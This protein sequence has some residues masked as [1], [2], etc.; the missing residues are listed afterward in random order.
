MSFN[1]HL[2][3]EWRP[4]N[5]NWR[6]FNSW[7]CKLMARVCFLFVANQTIRSSCRCRPQVIFWLQIYWFAETVFCISV[8]Q[9][10]WEC[11]QTRVTDTFS[12][13]K[14]IIYK[15]HEHTEPTTDWFGC[16]R[17]SVSGINNLNQ[18]ATNSIVAI[19][20]ELMLF[21]LKRPIAPLNMIPPIRLR[22][23]VWSF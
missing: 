9:A 15:R 7:R 13:R 8:C 20:T 14:L 6:F 17:G 1:Y 21:A 19:S 16:W 23:S 18:R 4:N 11:S 22:M 3:G 10:G 5:S 2:N 12:D